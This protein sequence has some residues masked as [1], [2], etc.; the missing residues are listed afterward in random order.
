MAQFFNIHADNPQPRLIQ[1]AVDILKRG[2]VIVYPTDS[3]YALGCHI[4]DKEA[5]MRLLW[6]WV[7]RYGI[8]RALYT[9]RKTVYIT[10]REPTVKGQLVDARN[11]PMPRERIYLGGAELPPST[12]VLAETRTDME[13]RFRFDNVPPR[14]AWWFTLPAHADLRSPPLNCDGPGEHRVRLRLKNPGNLELESNAEK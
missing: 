9:D 10:D 7:E 6:Q 13:G 12:S 4:G 11:R 2:G 14:R 8:P 5:A 1:Q 3:C